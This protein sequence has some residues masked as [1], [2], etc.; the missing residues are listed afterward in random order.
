[1]IPWR[2]DCWIRT[3]Q[4]SG[5]QFIRILLCLGIASIF[6]YRTVDVCFLLN[7]EMYLLPSL[8][9]GHDRSSVLQGLAFPEVFLTAELFKSEQTPFSH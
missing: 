9:S 5:Q 3:L 6:G 2:L 8:N 4:Q 7:I 1:M